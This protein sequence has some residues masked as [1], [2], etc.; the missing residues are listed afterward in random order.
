MAGTDTY[1]FCSFLEILLGGRHL[2]FTRDRS[3]ASLFFFRLS[4]SGAISSECHSLLVTLE[5]VKLDLLGWQTAVLDTFHCNIRTTTDGIKHKWFVVRTIAPS[6]NAIKWVGSIV[7]WERG[8][9]LVIELRNQSS[10]PAPCEQ[11]L[12]YL[13]TTGSDLILHGYNR[14]PSS[15]PLNR[16]LPGLLQEGTLLGILTGHS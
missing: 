15:E 14:H 8:N 1:S 13:T 9:L 5:V 12:A 2:N 10:G 4:P 3:R 11:A 16:V 6:H 7:R